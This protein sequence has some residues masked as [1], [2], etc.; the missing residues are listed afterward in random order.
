M[1]LFWN[2]LGLKF[3]EIG[4]LYYV[5]LSVIQMMNHVLYVTLK[6]LDLGAVGNS[7]SV[8]IISR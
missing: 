4:H 7:L 8:V 1:F 5:Q 3:I 6:S 2:N